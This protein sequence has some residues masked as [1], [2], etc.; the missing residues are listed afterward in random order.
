MSEVRQ[1]Q[2]LQAE[3]NKCIQNSFGKFRVMESMRNPAE[4]L[5]NISDPSLFKAVL[6]CL[7]SLFWNFIQKIPTFSSPAGI[8]FICIWHN[9]VGAFP[10]TKDAI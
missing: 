9:L 4:K 7:K 10:M 1:Q 6:I 3:Q 8:L 2:K 5:Q